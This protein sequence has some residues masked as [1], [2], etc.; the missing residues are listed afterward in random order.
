MKLA[1]LKNG[2]R[3]GRLVIVSRDLAHAVDAAG[4]AP[5]LQFALD[6][7]SR[8]EPDLLALA[9]QLDELRRNDK[10]PARGRQRS[11]RVRFRS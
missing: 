11:W 2:S 9:D 6:H 3:D 4:I 1:T 7:W 10:M 8:T 5:T